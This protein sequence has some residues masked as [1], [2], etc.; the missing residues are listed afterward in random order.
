MEHTA[1]IL[2]VMHPWTKSQPWGW[3]HVRNNGATTQ[4]THF[5]NSFAMHSSNHCFV[6]LKIYLCLI[7]L[8][9]SFILL[10]GC[11]NGLRKNEKIKVFIIFGS[12]SLRIYQNTT[13]FKE[14][15]HRKI[16]RLFSSKYW[17]LRVLTTGL[18]S[19]H[20]VL[21]EK[22]ISVTRRAEFLWPKYIR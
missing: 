20:D 5:F 14:K 12:Q 1:F 13:F 19:Q 18:Y 11:T 4:K 22:F 10:C 6:L 17:Y 9:F 3:G 8:S 15:R 7:T 2:R 16:G 21:N